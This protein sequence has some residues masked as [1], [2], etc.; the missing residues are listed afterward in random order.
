MAAYVDESKGSDGIWRLVILT[1]AFSIA[2]VSI[3]TLLNQ[4]G[5][6]NLTNR[7][8][9]LSWHGL[10]QGFV[11]QPLTYFLV[12]EGSSDGISLMFLINVCFNGYLLWFLGT[13]ISRLI[14]ISSFFIFYFASGLIAASFTI[15]LM[16]FFGVDVPLAGSTAALLSLLTLWGMAYAEAEVWLFFVIRIQAKWLVLTVFCALLLINVS[17]LQWVNLALYAS[18]VLISYIYANLAWGWKSPFAITA[19][20]ERFLSSMAKKFKETEEKKRGS[21]LQEKIID[22][23]TGRP[24]LGDEAFVDAM[25]NK[26][27]RQG[28][29]SLT[30]QERDR[31]KKIS[32]KKE[33]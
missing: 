3:E 5:I 24:I 23:T 32:E 26:I 20:F 10:N 17:H 31:L 14:D 22:F 30:W 15:G 28:E 6:F 25:L 27:S 33:R 12:Q 13:S 7:F 4:F 18:A 8:L 2:S 11:W 19:S 1:A 9:K 29:S 21:V 16:L